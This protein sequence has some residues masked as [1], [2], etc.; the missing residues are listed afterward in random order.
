MKK[1]N[2]EIEFLRFVFA[3]VIF[4]RHAAKLNVGSFP[5]LMENGALAV[6]FFFILTGWLM[7]RSCDGKEALPPGQG[8]T[9]TQS[10]LKK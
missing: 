4:M 10:Y 1:R 5:V 2:G 7:A 6:D 8:G 3:A 9:D